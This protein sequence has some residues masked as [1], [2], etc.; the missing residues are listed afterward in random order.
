M[1][2]LGLRELYPILSYIRLP[3]D[4]G[5]TVPGGSVIWLT[6]DPSAE[7]AAEEVTGKGFWYGSPSLDV[8]VVTVVTVG[9][10]VMMPTTAAEPQLLT[11]INHNLLGK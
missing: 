1:D 6:K 3:W 2:G 4:C 7:D 10:A 11:N 9:V 8:V 5:C